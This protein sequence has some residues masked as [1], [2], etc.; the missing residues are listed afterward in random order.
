MTL[1]NRFVRAIIEATERLGIPRARLLCAAGLDVTQVEAVEGRVSI[2]DFSKLCD[3]A[4]DLSEDP[5]LGLHAGELMTGGSFNIVTPLVAHAATMRQG[6]E[7]LARIHRLL[8]DRRRYEI[9]EHDHHATLR[10][11]SLDGASERVR[12]FVA[13]LELVAFWRMIAYFCPG[14]RPEAV[15]FEHAAPAH[16]REYTRAFDG[17]GRFD[18]PFTGIVFDRALLDVPSVFKDEAMHSALR[19]LAEHRIARIAQA[20]SHAKRVRDHL[21]QNDAAATDMAVVA[22]AL[23]LSV[24]SLRR[25]LAAERTSY[26]A[27][28]N[29]ALAEVAKRRLLVEG[30]TIQE[31]A[32]AMGYANSAAFHRAFKRW[33]GITPTAFIAKRN[34]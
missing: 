1:S 22:R 29:E 3:L 17:L 10:C 16:R 18:Q 6:F 15:S 27:L 7:T 13:E 28:V 26:Q 25:R 32:I 21:A 34:G 33:T 30:R 19:K 31:T 5:A 11:A 9:P 4:L 8:G 23:R 2:G 12:S 20:D 14:A 24:R